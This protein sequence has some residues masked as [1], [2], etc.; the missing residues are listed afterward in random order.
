MNRHS[1]AL[2]KVQNRTCGLWDLRLSRRWKFRFSRPEMW[3]LV[4][5]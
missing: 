5:C 1:A 4:L 3:R 2:L